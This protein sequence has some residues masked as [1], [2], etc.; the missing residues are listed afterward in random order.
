[1]LNQSKQL[2]PFNQI[3]PNWVTLSDYQQA[4]H[5][6]LPADILA[7]LEGDNLT[8]K[9]EPFAQV[10]PLSDWQWHPRVLATQV[11]DIS[12]HLYNPHAK[13]PLDI[14]LSHPIWLSPVAYQGLYHSDAELAT[15]LACEVT[16]TP[17]IWSCLGNTPFAKLLAYDNPISVPHAIHWY[18]QAPPSNYT[19]IYDKAAQRAYNLALLEPYFAMAASM[20][21]ITV[22]APHVGIRA[23]MR[24]HGFA[25]PSHLTT[26]NIPSTTSTMDFNLLSR[27]APTWEDMAWLVE[28]CPIPVILKGILHPDDAIQAQAIGC[29]GVFVSNHGRRVL[30]DCV[31][32]P[33][34]LPS[35][36]RAVPDM[37]IFAD[38]DVMSGSDV[39]K[40]MALGADTVGVGRGCIYGLAMAGSLGV[41]HGLRILL[42]EFQVINMLVNKSTQQ[43]I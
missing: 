28:H 41:A 7:Y 32:V 37:V 34:V 38:G 39:A 15:K 25:V 42:E 22:D 24:R 17:A 35:I 2:P 20:L 21:V 30:P 8:A 4:C 40:L 16:Q 31:S 23:N 18:W 27:T 33:Q 19:R 3:P 1:M 5:Q 14:R 9:L 29:A 26:P 11:P 10:S 13:V 43:L 12:C 36:R 6:Y